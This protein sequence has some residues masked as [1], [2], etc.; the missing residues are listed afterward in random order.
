M[1]YA[2]PIYLAPRTGLLPNITVKTRLSTFYALGS[3]ITSSPPSITS[4]NSATFTVGAQGSF[5]VIATGAPAPALS[6]FG[7][8]P[9]GVTF[10]AGTGVLSGKPASGT[11]GTY[12]I[13]F[14]ASNGVGSNSIQNFALT[15]TDWSNGYSNRLLITIDH[16]RV[17]NSDQLNF[18]MLFSGTYPYLA[19]TANG[20][21][22]TN[23]N[24]YDILF[25]SDANGT[26]PLAF[27]QE[28]YSPS[29]GTVNYWV[30][31]PTLS[32]TTDTVIYLFYGNSSV[33]TDQ[34][35]KS[36]VWDSN[37]LGIYHLPNGATLSAGDSTSGAHNGTL[38]GGPSAISAKI[39][40]G[41]SLA[42]AS[43]QDID[44][45]HQPEQNAFPLTISGW[46]NAGDSVPGRTWFLEQVCSSQRRR[47]SDV[48]ERRTHHRVVLRQR[49]TCP[50]RVG[51][52][53]HRQP[54][55]LL[56]LCSG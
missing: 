10:N 8:L 36:S 38:L 49:R 1:R 50:Q 43:N 34:S 30:K 40:G 53:N 27:E 39:G 56:R 22:V 15:V 31:I 42:S 14:T 2:F 13:M 16:T 17:P 18:P 51:T 4:A 54:M 24:G 28:S 12:N 32:H 55:A 33:T 21:S 35:N 6:E 5:T 52:D 19:T 44:V 20:G 29:T 45:P 46:I 3:G 11:A 25:T 41:A 47:L 26:S 23:A 9:S 7:P 48:L 37:Y